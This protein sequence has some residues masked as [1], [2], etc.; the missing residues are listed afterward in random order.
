MLFMAAAAL[1]TASPASAVVPR[2]IQQRTELRTI[3]ELPELST[4]FPIT[5]ME[6]IAPGTWR[7]TAGDCHIDVRFIPT[8]AVRP[9]LR[10]Y[11]P[12]VG[13]RVCER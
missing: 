6:L 10:R 13:R 1:A 4:F 11:T 2:H 9:G 3:L 5:R 7:L 12:Q 8:Q